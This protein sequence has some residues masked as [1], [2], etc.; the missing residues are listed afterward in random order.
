LSCWLPFRRPDVDVARRA[1]ELNEQA[2]KAFNL[3]ELEMALP[4]YQASL[5]LCQRSSNWAGVLRVRYAMGGLAFKSGEYG[6]ARTHF[7]ECVKLARKLHVIDGYLASLMWLGTTVLTQGDGALAARLGKE[8]LEQA[9]VVKDNLS[10]AAAHVLVGDAIDTVDEAR[11]HFKQALEIYRREA[12][13]DRVASVLCSIGHYAQPG[14]DN[15]EERA[16]LEECLVLCRSSDN[17]ELASY[18][19]YNLGNVEIFGGNTD[20][21][22]RLFSESLAIMIETGDDRA[23]S[24]VLDG[25]A[26]ISLLRGDCAK[27]ARLSGAAES[28]RTRLGTPIETPRQAEHDE[29]AAKMRASLDPTSFDAEWDAGTGL[30][31]VEAA[32]YA[33]SDGT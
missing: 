23:I 29:V 7:E 5:E 18:A 27:A 6:V 16:A 13:M 21:A 15:M 33:L 8:C 25:Y 17:R 31:V 28:V 2:D 32:D 22:A 11:S 24:Y 4:L 10:V 1:N 3:N 14:R 26:A 19:L 20:V 9:R 30:T 12:R